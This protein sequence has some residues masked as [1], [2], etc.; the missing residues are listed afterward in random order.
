MRINYE[1]ECVVVAIKVENE[2]LCGLWI[3]LGFGFTSGSLLTS[4]LA[5]SNVL[6][7][8]STWKSKHLKPSYYI[9]SAR[10]VSLTLR[11]ILVSPPFAPIR[12]HNN[13]PA[14]SQQASYIV[15]YVFSE[16][17]CF[18]SQSIDEIHWSVFKRRLKTPPNDYIQSA[19]RNSDLHFCFRFTL[20]N[21]H[22][23][24]RYLSWLQ[25]SYSQ[26][27]IKYFQAFGAKSD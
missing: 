24:L 23:V 22:Q 10:W 20:Q 12:I 27:Y 18:L 5:G 13:L 19:S 1:D 7:K 8:E 14:A 6:R 15:G 21:I 16:I 11:Q 4:S 2:K 3:S 25:Y 26:A 9:H 17:F